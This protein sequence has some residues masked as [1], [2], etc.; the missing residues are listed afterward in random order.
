MFSQ[1]ESEMNDDDLLIFINVDTLFTTCLLRN[2]QRKETKV[3]T[4]VMWSMCE[5]MQEPEEN[6]SD[7]LNYIVRIVPEGD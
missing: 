3:P 2:E 6:E 1:F 4:S 5:N 7:R